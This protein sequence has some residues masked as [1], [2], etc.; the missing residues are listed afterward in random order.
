MLDGLVGKQ[1]DVRQPPEQPSISS[2]GFQESAESQIT[3]ALGAQIAPAAEAILRELETLRVA[4]DVRYDAVTQAVAAL[5]A[6]SPA[7][8]HEV[9]QRLARAAGEKAEAA[10]RIARGQA[11]EQAQACLAFERAR[12]DERLQS[13]QAETMV[14]REAGLREQTALRRALEEA[15]A[16]VDA[17]HTHTRMQF[18]AAMAAQ[19]QLLET[20]R[21]QT[22]AARE[23]GERAATAHNHLVDGL[24]AQ[25]EQ[26]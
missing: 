11:A 24:R 6:A 23:E 19:T 16:Q 17:L 5:R 9:V 8:F 4:F 20:A 2:T 18:E 12:A 1:F 10:A 13:V 3:A 26:A 14:E 22:N 7:W 21:A 25:L 15:R